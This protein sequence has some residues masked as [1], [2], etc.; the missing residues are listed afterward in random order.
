VI[1][2]GQESESYFI[3]MEFVDGSDLKSLMSKE[4]K[5]VLPVALSAILEV[6]RGLEHAHSAGSCIA[7]SSRRT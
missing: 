6:L 1:D 5:V 7:T 3:A 4:P 2:F